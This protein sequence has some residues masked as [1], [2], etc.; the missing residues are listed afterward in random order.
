MKKIVL[1]TVLFSIQFLFSDS[2]IGKKIKNS[3]V[4]ML[5]GT[6][7]KLF[8]FNTDGPLII[9]FWTTWCT[10]CNNQIE[11]LNQMNEHFSEVGVSLLGVSINQPDIVNKVKPHAEKKNI[12]YDISIDP[13]SK[14]AKKFYVESIP[15]T[16]FIDNEGTILNEFIGFS[17]G[18]QNEILDVLTNYLDKQKI[19]YNEFEF[20]D[21][22]KKKNNVEIEADF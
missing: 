3:R 22:D 13:H 16:F 8:D 6:N 9:N 7:A 19:E 20:K 5:N 18:D 21:L 1:I 17:D 14:L 10:V 15:H 11:Y 4:K 12:G 2:I